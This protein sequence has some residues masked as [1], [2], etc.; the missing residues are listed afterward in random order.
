MADE[1]RGQSLEVARLKLQVSEQTVAIERAEL[2][3]LE[4]DDERG[5]LVT[6]ITAHTRQI[7][8][9]RKQIDKLSSPAPSGKEA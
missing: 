9:L 3:M 8:E 2:R 6:A 1:T 5:R 4:L 7:N